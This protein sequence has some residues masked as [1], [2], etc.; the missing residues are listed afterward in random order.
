M[1]PKVPIFS[2]FL[3]FFDLLSLKSIK[4]FSWVNDLELNDAEI[5]DFGEELSEKLKK[6]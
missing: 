1:N 6:H 5:V 2:I 4:G 3:F